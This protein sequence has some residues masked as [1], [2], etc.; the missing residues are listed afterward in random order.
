[1]NEP[2]VAD[3]V[4]RFR[5]TARQVLDVLLETHPEW[6]TEVGDHRFDDRLSDLG[7]AGAQTAA[8]L[9][10]DALG[11][12]DDVDDTA[13]DVPDQV[14]LEI[15][16]SATAAQLWLRTELREADRDPMQHLPTEGLYPLLARQTIPVPERLRA[17]TA[18]LGAVPE[19]LEQA[20]RQLTGMSRVH[21]ETAIVQAG[22]VLGMIEE[23]LEPLLEQEPR[24]RSGLDPV[25]QAAAQAV[26]DY[27]AWLAEQL[28]TA[29]GD[30][31]LGAERFAAKLWYTLDVEVGAEAL[32]VRAESDL[33]AVEDQLAELAG[34]LPDAGQNQV[35]G[36]LDRLAAQAPMADAGI[37]AACRQALADCTARVREL[38]LVTVPEDPVQIMVMPESRR[39]VAVAYCDPPGAL[40]A[41]GPDGQRAPTF[42]AVSPTPRDW[43]QARVASFYR[44][45][46]GHM[47]RNLTVH[48]AMPGHVLQ[49]A[50]AARLRAGTDVRRTL[51]SG[52]FVEGWAVYAE[53]LL[54]LP[55]LFGDGTVDGVGALG[56]RVPDDL[57]LRLTQLKMQLRTIINTILDIRVHTAGMTRPEAM[58]LMTARGHQEEGEAAGKWRR[59]LL[60]S[61]QLSTYYAGY[62][63][64][65]DL[66]GRARAA[67]PGWSTR[68]L[69]DA[70]LAHGSPP[71][72]HLAALL[73]V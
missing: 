45:Y 59:A 18:R 62:Q 2:P 69:H 66:A 12:L 72:R 1:M 32:L 57:A 43:D 3:G 39:G 65:R 73:G 51:W 31:R 4:D 67:H 47:V 44:E 46:N 33:L 38:D 71:P 25:R 22:G 7:A 37:L 49:L 58:T 63:G 15:L 50:H 35:R 40:E 21:V 27:R 55:G 64:V 36:V 10:T 17:L 54:A 9:L 68:R 61:T 26:G 8:G 11:A 23:E 20:R 34:Q 60:T 19:R 42:F 56:E 6:A 70:M 52:P 24:M 14:D 41:A 30:P 48:E 13:L 5:R 16:R 28:P 29:D 53:E